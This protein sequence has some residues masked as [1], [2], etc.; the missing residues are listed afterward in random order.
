VENAVYVRPD[1]H[2]RGIGRL[3]LSDQIDRARAA[4]HH[5]ILALIDSDQPASIA[6]HEA[7]GFERVA[8]LR[9]VGYK[10]GR[11]LHVVYMQRLL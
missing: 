6:L 7:L 3:L 8:F 9:E 5:A 4:G 10:F 11:W 2:R 1:H